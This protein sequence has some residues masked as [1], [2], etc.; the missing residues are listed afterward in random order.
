MMGAGRSLVQIFAVISVIA[1]LAGGAVCSAAAQPAVTFNKDIAPI[2]FD[3]CASCHR[4]GEIGPF[5]LLSYD[6]VR[7]HATQIALVT[8]RRVMPP[9]KPEPGKGEFIGDRSLTDAQIRVIHEWVAG[10]AKE[11]DP[12]DL[13]RV[14]Q[15]TGGWQLGTP[16]LVVSMPEPYA[17][18]ADGADVFRT[19]VIPIPTTTARYVKAIEFHPGNP[20]A[21]HHASLGVDRTRSS[22]RRD[23]LDPEPGYVGGM[24]ADAAYPPGFMLGWTPGQR[25]RPSPD[26]M[27]WRLER[28]SD[29]VVQLHMLPTGRPEAVQVSVGFFFTAEPPSRTPVGL[30][31][32]SETIEIAPGDR[33]Y[34]VTDSYRLP[35][36][37]EVLGIQPHAHNLAR[38]IDASATLPDGS[39][40]P[41]ISIPDWDFRWQDV[42][43]Y[44]RPVALPRGTTLSMRFTYD[45]S[46]D[47]PRNPSRPPRAVVWGQNTWDE[48]G[49]LWVQV[50]PHTSADLAVLDL[51]IG[52]KTRA[53]D[54]AAY[55]KLLDKSPD[56]PLRH[57]AV[58]ML[59]FQGG[60][61]QEAAA[62]F[63]ESLRLNP[64]SAPAHYN[65]GTA[66]SVQ[67]KYDEAVTEFQEAVR[68]DPGYAEAHNN[69]GAILHVLGRLDE[70]AEHYRRTIALRPDNMQARSNLGRLLSQQGRQAEAI[71]C[72][73]EA[74]AI[75]PDF[76]AA[77]YG[78]A[79]IRATSDLPVRDAKE[80]VRL[81]ERADALTQHKDP[82][83]L[84]VLAAA[85]A[86]AGLF[87]R[88]V[89]TGR[90]AAAAA[91]SAQM[92]SLASEILK[93]VALYEQRQPYLVR[94]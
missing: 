67:R 8:E 19:F 63:R 54:L 83:V 35:V 18:R 20:R 77:L 22:E 37:V 26:G 92:S 30:R 91:T 59:Y 42:Y 56:D 47:N 13:P 79:W 39:T 80:A 53:E 7:R 90:S 69:L 38:R 4:P 23:R 94:P 34:A 15:W 82:P 50:V 66:R 1:V 32:G 9:W 44:A 16:D 29:L 72:F 17:L 11:G 62:H 89:A 5:S 86:A 49:D 87:D 58:A 73:H 52:R 61:V 46:A 31:L 84:D 25:P 6:D 27:S 33:Q 65:L 48:M 36:D 3:H 21:V 10:G 68:L 81:A 76:A 55:T 57:D 88:A 78:L 75:S 24:V 64:G 85:Y 40:R 45:N 14:P 28:E 43:L 41:L 70:A 2:V 93:R 60:R 12:A 71:D 74:L 51:D